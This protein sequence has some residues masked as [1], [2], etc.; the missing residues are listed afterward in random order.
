MVALALDLLSQS[1]V[2]DR[3]D[4]AGIF[5]TNLIIYDIHS[6]HNWSFNVSL[7]PRLSYVLE[8]SIEILPD[9]ADIHVWVFSS[10]ELTLNLGAV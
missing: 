3:H 10:G 2:F 5:V 8:I 4:N 1:S 7:L 9:Q 6:T